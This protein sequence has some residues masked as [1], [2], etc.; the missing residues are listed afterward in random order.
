MRIFVAGGAGYIGSCTT[1]YLLDHG[2]EVAVYDA[3]LNGHR[4]AVDP[5]AKFYHANLEDTEAL[6]KALAEFKPEGVIH[7][8]AFIEVGESMKDPGK[9]FGNNVGNAIKLAEASH[10]ANVRKVVFSS[11]AAV[12]GMPDHVPINEEQPKLPINAYGES[13]L[14]FEHILDWYMKIYNM[15]YTALRYFNAAGATEIH[16]ED[17]NP[18]THL[19]P[20]ILQAAAGKRA[21]V[22]VFGTDYDTPDR[23]CIRDY[24]HVL[25]L[26]QAHLLA[27]QHDSSDVFNLGSGS[28][29]SVKEV[30]DTVKKVTG[31]DFN[32]NYTDRRPGDP[33][34]LVADSTK[35]RTVLDWKPQYDRLEDIVSS[36]WNWRMKHPDGY[37]DK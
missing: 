13:K 17:H 32:V 22:S 27:L 4:K 9:Y 20:I 35:A 29:Y 16:G 31:K 26:A 7:F 2:H 11:T 6:D 10:K 14:M 37:C 34:R 5:R 15:Q 36:A 24:V 18:E 25:D 8:A 12:Y 30:I 28:G 19:I 21:S 23:T 1:E 33:P 3:L